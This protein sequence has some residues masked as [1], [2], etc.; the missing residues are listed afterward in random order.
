MIDDTAESVLT[1]GA[2]AGVSALVS[3][4]SPV[5]RTI[6]IEDALRSTAHVRIALVLGHARTDAV[7][8]LRVSG[9]LVAR[10]CRSRF[11]VC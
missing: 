7:E 9:A 5:S 11:L 3:H 6:G 8:A 2:F 1:A 4:A 10:I